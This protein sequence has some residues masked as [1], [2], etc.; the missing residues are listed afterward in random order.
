MNFAS[1]PAE[2]NLLGK[3]LENESVEDEELRKTFERAD[4]NNFQLN[5]EKVKNEK[6]NQF[7][8]VATIRRKTQQ[9]NVSKEETLPPKQSSD[10][11][12]NN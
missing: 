3:R 12:M 8:Q 6:Q 1:S 11:I 9:S 4:L 2:A 7:V 5:E 10:Q